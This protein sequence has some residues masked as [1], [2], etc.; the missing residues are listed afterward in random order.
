MM[1]ED[2]GKKDVVTEEDGDA[3]D[4]LCKSQAGHSCGDYPK[5]LIGAGRTC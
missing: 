2:I 3:D 1:V 5:G 4:A